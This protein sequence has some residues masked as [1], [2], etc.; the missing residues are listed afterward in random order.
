MKIA[1][2]LINF[3]RM[4]E[5]EDRLWNEP[6]DHPQDVALPGRDV[7]SDTGSIERASGDSTATGQ[8]GRP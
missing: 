2:K 6:A 5:R 1:E 8:P 4:L 7:G 3:M